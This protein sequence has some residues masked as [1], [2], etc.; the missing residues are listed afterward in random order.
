[1]QM[2]KVIKDNTD[3]VNKNKRQWLEKFKD[4]YTSL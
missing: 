2:I 1:M 4:I 3:V